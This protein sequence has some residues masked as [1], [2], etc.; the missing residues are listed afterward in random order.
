MST[1]SPDHTSAHD[2]R[3]AL[4]GFDFDAE[5]D[6]AIRGDEQH[7]RCPPSTPIPVDGV[8][9][10]SA[11]AV[12]SP[13]AGHDGRLH[14]EDELPPVHEPGPKRGPRGVRRRRRGRDGG[15]RRRRPAGRIPVRPLQ[16]R[17]GRAAGVRRI[18]AAG[19]YGH[20]AGPLRCIRFDSSDFLSRAFANGRN[21]FPATGTQTLASIHG[22]FVRF[23]NGH[24][25]TC[26]FI[27][28]EI[29]RTFEKMSSQER[30]VGFSVEAEHDAG[31]FLHSA[32]RR[33][34]RDSEYGDGIVHSRTLAVGDVESR[35]TR[36]TDGI[37]SPLEGDVI[38]PG[39]ALL[40]PHPGNRAWKALVMGHKAEYDA[41]PYGTKGE[42]ARKIVRAVRA[43]S[44]RFLTKDE[45]T[46]L[47]RDIGDEKA[48]VRT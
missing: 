29:R 39:Q 11:V 22:S 16:A 41:R 46:G 35:K 32:V 48:R 21:V 20:A 40:N 31:V 10:R 27:P 26:P 37:E 8:P 36:E 38:V 28:R 42:I 23:Q 7:A 15:A 4:D 12:A 44:G 1:P 13:P 30:G 47:W 2:G 9:R 17:G 6:R 45:R 43:A 14:G 3:A 19:A 5:L 33:G 34:Y 18:Q 24:F 25:R